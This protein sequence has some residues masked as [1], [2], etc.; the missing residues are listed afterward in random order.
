MKKLFVIV[1]VLF[2]TQDILAQRRLKYSDIFAGIGKEKAEDTYLKLKE[3]QKQD[4][5]FINTYF[6]SL[7][8][9][10]K[11]LKESD[12]FLNPDENSLLRY[13]C[14][15]Y[16]NLSLGKL[17]AD[18]K[19]VK[20]NKD[21]Y[22]NVQMIP[23]MASLEHQ[24]VINYLEKLKTEI[25]EYDQNVEKILNN[26]NHTVDK[27][28]HCMA[29]FRDICARQINYKDLI[30]DNSI[31][32][33]QQ[34]EELNASFDSVIYFFDEYKTSI[35]NYPI[36]NYDQKRNIIPINVYRLDGLTSSDFL[37]ANVN[38]WDYS[39]WVK[40][41]FKEMN[42][43]V[44]EAKSSIEKEIKTIRDK[45]QSVKGENT[46]RTIYHELNRK[47]LYHNEK[48]DYHSIL[49][50][51]LEYETEL[52]NLRIACGKS[53]NSTTDEYSLKEPFS[54][55]I[56]YLDLLMERVNNTYN[57][58][59]QMKERANKQNL[60][61]HGGVIN[62]L[63]GQPDKLTSKIDNQ[64]KNE[65]KEIENSIL[66]NIKFFTDLDNNNTIAQAT[67]LKGVK[68]TVA[69]SNVE[70]NNATL[71]QAVTLFNSS[72]IKGNIAVC[73][74]IKNANNSK[75][76]VAKVAPNGTT[77]MLSTFDCAA[78][79]INMAHYA[80]CTE[81][82]LVAVCSSSK[83]GAIKSYAISFDNTG[84]Q[85]SNIDLGVTQIPTSA[86]FDE[87]MDEMIV[88]CQN[89]SQATFVKANFSNKQANILGSLDIKG[90]VVDIVKNQDQY[91][92]VANFTELNKQAS[93][94]NEI[95]KI[96]ISNQ[97]EGVSLNT[98]KD[99]KAIKLA[100][101][102]GKLKLISIQNNK[103]CYQEIK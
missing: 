75:A 9:D 95:A 41:I 50:S 15:L 66:D 48:Y 51:A 55:K 35:K 78:M 52:C 28:N 102:N 16:H 1:L 4:P 31:E 99:S 46:D 14:K 13:D 79:A 23:N 36:K 91:I 83:D 10:W 92:A 25:F 87:I 89:E 37:Q 100:K 53:A 67:A 60:S 76:F 59:N 81:N 19:D 24:D 77:T 21:F 98:Q 63:Y 71:N 57:Y 88:S 97:V 33:K 34:L 93:N 103:T 90:E 29:I 54:R 20:K 7:L 49:S 74:Y 62:N 70:F 44:L 17:K 58:L 96:T 30:L 8:I 65:V 56:S 86:K 61:K 22:S 82:G 64:L 40:Q 80:Y 38:L 2:A 94:N 39:S 42:G 101:V 6:Q 32:L 18:E 3:Y 45:A 47:V 27:Y 68:F 69:N 26:Y 5:T 72:D 73:G 85:I 84:K 43:P 12:P 11:W